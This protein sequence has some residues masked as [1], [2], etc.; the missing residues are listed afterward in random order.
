VWRHGTYGRSETLKL[1]CIE[2]LK[3]ASGKLNEWF[4]EENKHDIGNQKQN[5]QIFLRKIV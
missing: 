2:T 5:I 4:I 1:F 3:Y